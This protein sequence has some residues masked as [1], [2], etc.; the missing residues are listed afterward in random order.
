MVELGLI[1]KLRKGWAIV[2]G[3]TT[4]LL[5]GP[6]IAAQVLGSE[7]I[8]SVYIGMLSGVLA[9]SVGIQI[10][11]GLVQPVKKDLKKLR[12]GVSKD[13]ETY[14]EYSPEFVIENTSHNKISNE[15]IIKVTESKVATDAKKA[16]ENELVK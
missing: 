9:A 5:L 7:L 4:A 12:E 3:V 2:V 16:E 13:N 1:K 14:K 11:L 8:V 6:A 10:Y 15:Q